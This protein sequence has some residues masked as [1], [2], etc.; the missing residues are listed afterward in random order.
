[1]ELMLIMSLLVINVK[2]CRLKKLFMVYLFCL[3]FVCAV[4]LVGYFIYCTT[5]LVFYKERK[6]SKKTFMKLK[7]C[8]FEHYLQARVDLLLLWDMHVF[9]SDHQNY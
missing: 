9:C 7:K 1:M 5:F 2:V 4:P 3:V 8:L 6:L